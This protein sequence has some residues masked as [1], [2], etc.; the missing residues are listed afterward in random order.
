MRQRYGET[1]MVQRT[2]GAHLL[3]V[4]VPNTND[5]ENLEIT[6]PKPLVTVLGL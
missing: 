1:M 2:S 5:I 4:F 6:S 3:L